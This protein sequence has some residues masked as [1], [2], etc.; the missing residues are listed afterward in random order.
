MRGKSQSIVLKLPPF[1]FLCSPA[2]K[3]LARKRVIPFH[4]LVLVILYGIFLLSATIEG[5]ILIRRGIGI[6]QNPPFFVHLLCSALSIPLVSVFASR[7]FAVPKVKEEQSVTNFFVSS[8]RISKLKNALFGMAFAVGLFSLAY[9]IV[10]S[11][12]YRNTVNIYDS[13][14]HPLSFGSYFFVRIYV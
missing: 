6:L 10:L 1:S 13:L 5:T 7:I 14:A 2:Q 8:I 9:T 4:C 12:S 3:W 11:I